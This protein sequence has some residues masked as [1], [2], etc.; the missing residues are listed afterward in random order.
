M[1]SQFTTFKELDGIATIISGFLI[2]GVA[3]RFGY[4]NMLGL[5]D[6][7]APVLSKKKSSICC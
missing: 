7:A 5:I 4:D 2:I 6:V 3:F 1:V